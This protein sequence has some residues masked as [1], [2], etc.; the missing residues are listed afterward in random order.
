MP[1]IE[2][3]DRIYIDRPLAELNPLIESAGQLDYVIIRLLDHFCK[4]RSFTR[5]ATGV[6]VLV[7]VLFEFVRRIVNV[8]EDTKLAQ[9]GDVF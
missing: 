5:F 6:G 4:P 7:L 1:Y 3:G 9:N 8:Y 2:P